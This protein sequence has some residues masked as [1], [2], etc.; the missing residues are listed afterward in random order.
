MPPSWPWPVVPMTVIA[1]AWVAM[2]DSP[3]A[4]QGILRP[5]A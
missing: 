4:H 2:I 3:A 1:L 5:A